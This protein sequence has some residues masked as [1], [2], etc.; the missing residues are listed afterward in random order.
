VTQGSKL[1]GL[2]GSPGISELA[3]VYGKNQAL[4]L[5]YL[6]LD[7]L[8]CHHLLCVTTNTAGTARDESL[9]LTLSVGLGHGVQ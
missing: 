8:A 4:E 7:P 5:G 9:K 1:S 6:G 3:Q 2:C